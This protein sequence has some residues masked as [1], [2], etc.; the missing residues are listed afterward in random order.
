MKENVIYW[1]R[2]FL[3]LP[4]TIVA[5][6]MATFPL[7]WLLYFA[8]ASGQEVEL[9]SVRFFIELF[10]RNA[11]AESIEYT[12][13]PFVIAAAFVFA[14]YKLAPK[15][16]FKTAI[17]LFVVYVIVWTVIHIYAFSHGQDFSIRILLALL[18][19]VL[20]LGIA[21]T[22]STNKD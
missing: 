1:S 21:K 6:I 12:L 14:G 20:G 17:A 19:A 2:W 16:K 15:Y 11:S 8:Y 4:G 3:V 7:H 9:G 18:G 13:T 10:F 5:G 22:E